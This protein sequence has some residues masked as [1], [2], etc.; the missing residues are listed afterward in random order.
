[1]LVASSF[2]G[3]GWKRGVIDGNE[4][5]R[6]PSVLSQ[7]GH[8][9][10]VGRDVVSL[11]THEP[12]VNGSSASTTPSLEVCAMFFV[13]VSL[14]VFQFSHDWYGTCQAVVQSEDPLEASGIL[15]QA[16]HLL[17][18]E[19]AGVINHP[20]DEIDLLA[21][22]SPCTDAEAK[23]HQCVISSGP[24]TCLKAQWEQMDKMAS[25]AGR[26]AL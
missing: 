2:V 5:A 26:P 9:G 6:M 20:L 3:C 1:M 10:H 12:L 11:I 24:I 8:A 7:T 21:E 18:D 13:N 16:V 22:V 15:R 25:I 19:A 23:L 4:K 17:I 14:T